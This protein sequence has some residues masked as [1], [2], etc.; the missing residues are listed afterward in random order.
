MMARF[1][2]LVTGSSGIRKHAGTR[3]PNGIKAVPASQ[4]V[5]AF[6]YTYMRARACVHITKNAVTTRYAGTALNLKGFS[7]PA[8]TL[9]PLL[10][11]NEG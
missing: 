5:T 7:V 8:S 2:G 4:A 6:P 3:K 10:P 11:V 1:A 9:M